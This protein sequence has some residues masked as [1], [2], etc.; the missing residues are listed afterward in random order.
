M[1]LCSCIHLLTIIKSFIW[2]WPVLQSGSEVLAS[3]SSVSAKNSLRGH[4]IWRMFTIVFSS[5]ALDSSEFGNITCLWSHLLYSLQADSPSLQTF[6]LCGSLVF[7]YHTS[8]L[9]VSLT[10]SWFSAACY[11]LPSPRLP[12][13]H[14]VSWR[15]VHTDA[16]VTVTW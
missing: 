16:G 13:P 14:C 1:I 7:A 9:S 12:F 2:E 11:A 10:F 3:C 15:T 8:C 4:E 5:C 6:Q